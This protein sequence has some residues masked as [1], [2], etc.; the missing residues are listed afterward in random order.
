MSAHTHPLLVRLQRLNELGVA[1]SSERDPDKLLE[2]ILRGAMSLT[3]ADGGSLY[4]LD[5]SQQ[6]LR[7]SIVITESMGIFSGGTS[8]LPVGIPPLQMYT[9]D[10]QPNLAT[11]A[12]HAALQRITLHVTD[13]YGNSTFDF[14]K[15]KEFDRV[16][17]YRT[18][19]LL[20][21]PLID[22]QNDVIGVLQLINALDNDGKPRVFSSSDAHLAE[23]LAS[24]AAV[25][26]TNRRLIDAQKALFDAVIE[27]IATAIDEKSPYT[28]GHC[29]RVPEIAQMIATAACATTH[30]PLADFT[31]NTAD[32]YELKVAAL[33]HDCGKVTTPVHVMDK[34]TK[35]HTLF[36]RIHLV[37]T[38]IELLRRERTLAALQR[39]FPE[40]AAALATDPELQQELTELKGARDFLRKVNIGGERM[41][42]EDQQR[43]RTLAAQHTWQDY[44]G[45]PQHFLDHDEIENLT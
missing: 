19:S 6:L 30:G 1:L 16:F 26:L 31:M 29:R 21:V 43:V 40:V 14:S 41:M 10:G 3:H 42:P 12:V 28:G 7:F 39:R 36:D 15:V 17:G 8:G 4:L 32:F 44:D 22:H 13:T 11:V 33:L 2:E 25:A 23:S 9:A 37:D 5:E 34:S 20:A 35:L 38:R 45:Q 27:M 18:H 24:Q